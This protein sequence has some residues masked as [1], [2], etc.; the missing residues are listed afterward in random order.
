MSSVHWLVPLSY[1]SYL[2]VLRVRDYTPNKWLISTLIAL[3][4]VATQRTGFGLSL[5][6]G[7]KLLALGFDTNPLIHYCRGEG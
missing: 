6:I 3:N 4:V 2:S 7:E 5:R 1:I